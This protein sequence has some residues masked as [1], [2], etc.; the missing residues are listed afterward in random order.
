MDN[1]ALSQTNPA[2][3]SHSE[4]VPPASSAV[5]HVALLL[6]VCG[7][8]FLARSAS[9]PLMDPDE[10]R[11]AII[12]RNMLRDGDWIVPHL[13]GKVYFDKPAPFFWLAAIARHFT[14]N[15]EL[16]GRLVAALAA[17][18]A[19][20][21]AWALGRRMFGPVSGLL[22]GFFLATMGEFLFMARWY[23]MDMPF[24]AAMWAAFWWF[25]RQERP[26]QESQEKASGSQWIGFYAFCG[27]STLFKGPAG[28]VLPALAIAAY[29]MLSG[30]PRRIL[31]FFNPLG[32]LV[33]LL[34]AAP[35]YVL[36]ILRESNYVHEF[37]YNQ[38]IERF[39]HPVGS[40]G[41]SG[42]IYIPVLLGGVMPWTI[43]LVGAVVRYFP[44]RWKNRN[45]CPEA[46][47]LWC[48]A[49]V[50][51]VF[52]SLSKT[53]LL[54]Y[55]LPVM[56]PLAVLIGGLLGRWAQSVEPDRLL[57]ALGRAMMV[58]LPLVMAVLIL[59]VDIYLQVFDVWS[60]LALAGA[61][62]ISWRMIAQFLRDR[63][64]GFLTWMLAGGVGIYLY[65]ILHSFPAAYEMMSTKMLARL[66]N[67]AL[68]ESAKFL[69]WRHGK[70]SFEYYADI[71]EGN[72]INT[73][74]PGA[75]E[76]IAALMASDRPVYC[77]ISDNE[78]LR[79]MQ[80][81]CAGHLYILGQSGA[82]G[83]ENSRRYLV[84]NRPAEEMDGLGGGLAP[85]RPPSNPSN[86]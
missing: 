60:V 51:F 50:P 11:C 56:P 23:R 64:A 36:I 49:L 67:P 81:A 40:H 48:A 12:V 75:L 29:F 34:I 70:L 84:A 5:F 71:P 63:R 35:W 82:R 66:V 26:P 16:A 79:E 18:G 10:A 14:G 25:W 22:A 9:L 78:S 62:L 4:L 15:V 76:R 7:A 17:L 68:R 2:E 59:G 21:A 6:A 61:L 53:K 32:I 27:V 13:E 24:V 47:F 74:K 72:G 65:F 1:P 8:L 80:K 83:F 69:N 31:E 58:L 54:G 19:V 37:F 30:R 52:F 39:L 86:R 45:S 85:I 77:F 44:R 20:L 43:Y 3:S 57:K 42:F 38:N 46:L 33:Y 55:I 41:L 28:L 73:S